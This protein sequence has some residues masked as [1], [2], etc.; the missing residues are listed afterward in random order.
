MMRT[1]GWVGKPGLSGSGAAGSTGLARGANAG[2][3]VTS[4]NR[5]IAGANSGANNGVRA[6]VAAT[7]VASPNPAT[8]VTPA[9]TQ[10]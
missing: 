5:V 7:A 8:I 2:T 3:P 6:K 4:A 10:R 1:C 9:R